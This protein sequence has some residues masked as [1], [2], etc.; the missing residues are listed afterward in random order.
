MKGPVY[1]II[2]VC[3]IYGIFNSL[4]IDIFCHRYWHFLSKIFK[5]LFSSGDNDHVRKEEK[6]G[7][8]FNRAFDHY[9]KKLFILKNGFK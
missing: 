3:N 2:V 4:D 5:V 9:S 1:T 6:N 8:A 7:K